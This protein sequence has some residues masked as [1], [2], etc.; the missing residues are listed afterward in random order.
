MLPWTCLWHTKY[1]LGL[2]RCG[3]SSRCLSRQLAG[4]WQ[5]RRQRPQQ[6]AE[7]VERRGGDAARAQ[8]RPLPTT[9]S[10]GDLG[11][12]AGVQHMQPAAEVAGMGNTGGPC[13]RVIKKTT[14]NVCNDAMM[15]AM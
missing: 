14:C 9:G 4:S 11:G 12:A 6:Q 8:R 7:I 15:N 13:G 5:T 3:R 2:R 10:A 1:M